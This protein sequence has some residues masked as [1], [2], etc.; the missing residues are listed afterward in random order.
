MIDVVN[1][2]ESDVPVRV[3]STTP[4]ERWEGHWRRGRLYPLYAVVENNGS[5]FMSLTGKEKAEPYVIYD[6]DAEAF[7]ANEGWVIKE[8]S[9]DSRLTAIGGNVA[10]G[11][12]SVTASVDGNPA[13]VA[14]TVGGPSG[15]KTLDFAFTGLKGEKGDV[16]YFN[17][18]VD[19]GLYLHVEDTDYGISSKLNFDQ[20]TGYLTIVN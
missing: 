14:V 9:A 6:H 12:A 18:F 19:S 16:G 13:Q 3:I 15:A 7:Y 17:M 10:A 20:A 11:L 2:Q 8:M 1:T 4:R 5:K